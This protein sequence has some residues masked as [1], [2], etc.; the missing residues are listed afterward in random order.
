M[1]KRNPSYKRNPSSLKSAYQK[2]VVRLPFENPSDTSAA[3][4]V[5]GGGEE[6]SSSIIV[7]SNATI[8]SINSTFS[9]DVSDPNSIVSP[10]TIL[11]NNLPGDT[12][13]TCTIY[14][15]VVLFKYFGTHTQNVITH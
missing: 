8:D 6:Y 15:Y 9:F 5:R 4:L 2:K 11:I 7:S 12:Q 13:F 3:K 1:V 14:C 10:G